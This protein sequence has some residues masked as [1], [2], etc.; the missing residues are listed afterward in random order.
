MM[1]ERPQDRRPTTTDMSNKID[2]RLEG[3]FAAARQ[4]AGDRLPDALQARLLGDALAHIPP[5]AQASVARASAKGHWWRLADWSAN[6]A[7]AI[8]GTPGLA[9]V[10]AAGLAGVWI[11]VAAP[12][13]AADLV[14]Y[15]GLGAAVVDAGAAGQI[16]D[17]LWLSDDGALLAL[18][19]SD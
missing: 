12:G 17:A 9:V 3:F 18:M 13:P 7:R 5:L 1:T 14:G 15:A 11:G 8:G 16:D 10:S 4:D 19:D 2:A 6:L